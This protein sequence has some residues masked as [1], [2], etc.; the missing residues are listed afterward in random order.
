MAVYAPMPNRNM[1]TELWRKKK[2]WLYFFAR[3]RGNTVGWRLKNCPPSALHWGIGRG[4]IVKG[5]GQR[6][7][8]RIKAATVLHS[9]F[10]CTVSKGC[11]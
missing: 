2:E 7:E 11:C 8:I 4:Y 9:S 3:Q 6:Y 5:S 1:E 10:F